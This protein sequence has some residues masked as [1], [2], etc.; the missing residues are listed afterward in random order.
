MFGKIVKW[1]ESLASNF[2]CT[3]GQMMEENKRPIIRIWTLND[4]TGVCAEEDWGLDRLASE[5]WLV[6]YP[7]LTLFRRP[8]VP[9]TAFFSD[10][11]PIVNSLGDF[12]TGSMADYENLIKGCRKERTEM[13][14]PVGFESGRIRE[15]GF[16]PVTLKAAYRLVHGPDAK[17]PELAS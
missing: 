9:L 8:I 5:R 2:L 3:L 17:P 4:L 6:G 13:F 11:Q 12:C 15:C 10:E 7:N 16:R 1:L 14:I